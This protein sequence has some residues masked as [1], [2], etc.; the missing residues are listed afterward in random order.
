[1]GRRQGFK[2]TGKPKKS[3][4]AIESEAAGCW[5]PPCFYLLLICLPVAL[6]QDTFDKSFLKEL[7]LLPSP[8]VAQP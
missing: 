6:C 8:S 7:L 1:M 2:L 5:W 4:C 3:I